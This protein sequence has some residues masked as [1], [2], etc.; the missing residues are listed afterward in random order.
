M[1]ITFGVATAAGVNAATGLGG[2]GNLTVPLPAS[3]AVGQLA[4]LL[5]WNEAGTAST[6]TNWTQITGSPWGTSQ[7]LHAFY[8]FLA[9]SEPN[10]TTTISGDSTTTSHCGA[11]MTFNNVDPSTPVEVVGTAGTGTGT[12]MIAPTIST[13]TDGAWAV[14][15]CGRGDNELSSAQTFGDSATGVTERL[16]AGTNVDDDSQVSAYSKEITSYGDVGHGDATTNVT[17]PYVTVIVAL[18]P[19]V[20]SPTAAA[21]SVGVSASGAATIPSGTINAS[22][23][24]GLSASGSAVSTSGTVDAAGT[25]GIASAHGATI[26]AGGALPV[27]ASGSI[28]V[29]SVGAA[30]I[31]SLLSAPA[32][33]TVGVEFAASA[34]IENLISVL[35]FGAVGL[36]SAVSATAELASPPV[37]PTSEVACYAVLKKPLSKRKWQII[38]DFLMETES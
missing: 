10:P 4:I 26:E 25:V 6:P 12:P 22:G 28:G 33:G 20:A 8:K 38:R 36:E 37:A 11:I 17:D 14:G 1:A 21:G 19:L 9:T 18:K 29:S 23:A 3:W 7:T 34:T 24:V 27:D 32:N 15:L 2:N 31:E 5:V 35:A 16:D 13:L 30:T